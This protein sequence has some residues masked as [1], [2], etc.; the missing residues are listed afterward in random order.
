M[1]YSIDLNNS[2]KDI[3]ISILIIS[4]EGLYYTW[5]LIY[6]YLISYYYKYDKDIKM[7]DGFRAFLYMFI[8][9]IVGNWILSSFLFKFG[10]KNTLRIGSLAYFL[11]ICNYIMIP[12]R[13]NLYFNTFLLGI[14]HQFKI[15]PINY[16]ISKKYENGINYL[17]HIYSG[18]SI[19]LLIWSLLMFYIINPNNLPIQKESSSEY[20]HY[21]VSKN[22]IKYFLINGIFSIIIIFIS[23][24]FLEEYN[25]KIPFNTELSEISFGS[26]DSKYSKSE[27]EKKYKKSFDCDKNDISISLSD[28]SIKDNELNLKELKTI[29]FQRMKELKFIAII[30]III[31]K[32]ASCS[33]YTTNAKYMSFILIKNDKLIAFIYSISALFDFG[34]RYVLSHTWENYGFFRTMILSFTISIF[35]NITYILFGNNNKWVFIYIFFVQSMIF[36]T[37]YL[38]CNMFLFHS[39]N[40]E[41]AVFLSRFFEI[42]SFFYFLYDVTL[43]EI[44]V[45]NWEFRYLFLIFIFGEIIGL[46]VFYKCFQKTEINSKIKFPNN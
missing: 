31:I 2:K 32:H 35:I 33:Y 16:H 38:L 41:I 39:Y 1:Y 7:I 17:K 24:I 43:N 5:G 15:I 18:F 27:K 10:I 22:I 20:Y 46:I 23:T 40:P 29:A 45:K 34:A 6:P 36:S 25:K 4:T 37:Q 30:F 44:F 19:G 8:G 13:I 42:Y 3:I 12:C 14:S 21:S 11:V 26:E 28:E 9:R